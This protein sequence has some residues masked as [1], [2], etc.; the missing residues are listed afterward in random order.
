MTRDAAVRLWEVLLDNGFSATVTGGVHEKMSPRESYSVRVRAMQL[1]A[2]DLRS[3]ATIGEN[4][5]LGLHLIGG[6]LSYVA[7]RPRA[8]AP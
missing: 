6:E 5:G 2:R 1:D 8:V 3:L 4:H 7:E